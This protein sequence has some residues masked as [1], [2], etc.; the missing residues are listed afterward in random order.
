MGTDFP[1]DADL[2]GDINQRVVRRLV[3]VAG[4]VGRGALN[5]WVI[6][7]R[8]CGGVEN[9]HAEFAEELN[10]CKGLSEVDVDGVRLIHAEGVT[11][12]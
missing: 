3:A 2:A 1:H 12:G 10:K 5:V 8:A 7:G 6:V 11:V 4:R 9:L